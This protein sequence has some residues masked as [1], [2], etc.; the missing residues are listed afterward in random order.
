M[1]IEMKK[2]FLFFAVVA[3]V[4]FASCNKPAP[5]VDTEDTTTVV[6]AVV[7]DSAA[8]AVEADSTVAEVA[9]VAE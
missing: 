1:L 6:E 8:V 4:A 9:P 7:E 3:A 5:A 2:V